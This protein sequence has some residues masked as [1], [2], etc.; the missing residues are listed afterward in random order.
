MSGRQRTAT[1][2]TSIR[3]LLRR[4]IMY[5][6]SKVASGIPMISGIAIARGVPGGSVAAEGIEITVPAL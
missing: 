6:I 4:R 2:R 5:A 1:R 3:Y